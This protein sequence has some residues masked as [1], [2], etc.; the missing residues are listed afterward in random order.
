MPYLHEFDIE[1]SVRPLVS[2]KMEDSDILMFR[3]GCLSVWTGEEWLPEHDQ[4]PF[5]DTKVPCTHWED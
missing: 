4:K 1:V 2:K 5:I 3:C